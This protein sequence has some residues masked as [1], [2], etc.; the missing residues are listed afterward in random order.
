MV[1]TMVNKSCKQ[2]GLAKSEV[3][4]LRLSIYANFNISN[5][6]ELLR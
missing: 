6:I 4:V 2:Q 1:E 3:E 5:S